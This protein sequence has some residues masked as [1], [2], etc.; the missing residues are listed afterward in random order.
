[1]TLAKDTVSFVEFWHN[2]LSYKYYQVINT[3][4]ENQFRRDIKS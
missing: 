2:D 4:V 1:M 3:A